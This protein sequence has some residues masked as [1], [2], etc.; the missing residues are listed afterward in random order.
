GGTAAGA[1]VGAP[2]MGRVSAEGGGRSLADGQQ[3]SQHRL[4]P[5][6]VTDPDQPYGHRP[7][8]AAGAAVPP[9]DANPGGERRLDVQR[10]D[11]A[12]AADRPLRGGDPVPALEQAAVRYD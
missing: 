7:L 8:F 1:D 10:H 5:V 12:E 6:G 2:A 11:S 3:G 4:Q 9:G